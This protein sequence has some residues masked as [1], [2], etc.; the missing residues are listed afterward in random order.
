MVLFLRQGSSPHGAK[1]RQPV[2]AEPTSPTRRVTPIL[3]HFQV[4]SFIN[5]GVNSA[6]NGKRY[7][8]PNFWVNFWGTPHRLSSSFYGEFGVESRQK[9]L[10]SHRLFLRRRIILTRSAKWQSDRHRRRIM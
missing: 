9:Q 6:N 5:R 10:Q 1:R 7:L 2:R 4:C 8:R 3:F